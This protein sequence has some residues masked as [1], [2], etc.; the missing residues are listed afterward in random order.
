MEFTLTQSSTV[1][2]SALNNTT[3]THQ[4]LNNQRANHSAY[5]TNNTGG[6]SAHSAVHL[7]TDTGINGTSEDDFDIETITIVKAGGPLGLSIVGG[8]DHTSHPFGLDEPGIFI[9]KVIL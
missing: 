2:S 3:Q 9:S 4:G 8:T 6:N 5:N 7:S 1:S